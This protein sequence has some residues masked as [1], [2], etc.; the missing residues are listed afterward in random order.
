MLHIV[1]ENKNG[2][3]DFNGGKG[4]YP[5]RILEIDGLGLTGKNYETAEYP[6]GIGQRTLSETLNARTI[7][8]QCDVNSIKLLHR[9]VIC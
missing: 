6:G 8:I 9:A 7:S 4:K 5:W 3:L 2:K 1:Y